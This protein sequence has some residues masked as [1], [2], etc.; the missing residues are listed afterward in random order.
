ML[1]CPVNATFFILKYYTVNYVELFHLII[2]VVVIVVVLGSQLS[3]K[4]FGYLR[5]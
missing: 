2:K 4:I 1:V 5:L 3:V